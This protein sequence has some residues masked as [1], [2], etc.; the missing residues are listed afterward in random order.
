MIMSEKK[1]DVDQGLQSN[2]NKKSDKKLI[3]S[4]QNLRFVHNCNLLK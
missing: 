1:P 3:K 4:L 2:K